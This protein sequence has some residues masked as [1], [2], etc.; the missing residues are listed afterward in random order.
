[1]FL[2]IGWIIISRIARKDLNTPFLHV[3]VQGVNREYIFGKE[4]YIDSYLEIV[5]KNKEK[6]DFTIMAYCIMS[7]HAH[8]LMYAED[9]G[10]IG[11]F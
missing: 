6:F 4:E 7:N 11:T 5:N 8:F 2:C 3:M 1:M 10:E 9:V